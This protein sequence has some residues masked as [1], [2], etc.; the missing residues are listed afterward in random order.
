VRL[1][2]LRRDQ[3][4][5]AVVEFALVAPLL[6]L[7]VFGILDFGR[8]LNYYNQMTQLSGQGARAAAVSNNPDGSAATGLS[9]QSQLAT[10]YA[11]GGLQ[12]GVK[13]CISNGTTGATSAGSEPS[14]GQAVRV[15]TTYKFN[16]LPLIGAAVG[17]G[18]INLT[19]T[20]SERQEIKA[21]YSLGCSP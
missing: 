3:R 16:F 12:N 2:A 15:Q 1:G 6:F 19:A 4:G 9:I 8:A 7:L 10:Q 5:T 20:Q 14:P 13:V 21:T 18:S 17:G 11:N